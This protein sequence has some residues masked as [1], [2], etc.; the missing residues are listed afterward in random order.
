MG[1]RRGPFRRFASDVGR[2]L[3]PEERG[4]HRLF[5]DRLL[6]L[7][8]LTLL[9]WLVVSIVMFALERHATGTDIHNPWQAIYWTASAMTAIG[10]N[11]ANPRTPA[12]HVLDLV[13]KLYA[14]LV[15]ASLTGA[16]GAFFVH[17]KDEEEST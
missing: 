15:V 14:I 16:V 10:S 2:V 5:H 4:A 13:L 1:D 11:Y 7:G 17:T 3:R 12:A 8:L 6:V 9:V